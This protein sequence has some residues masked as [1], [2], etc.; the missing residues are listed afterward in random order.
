MQKPEQIL[1]VDAA[2]RRYSSY[3]PASCVD[4][5]YE[6]DGGSSFASLDGVE[7][8]L[9]ESTDCKGW[10]GE[11]YVVLDY[12]IRSVGAFARLRGDARAAGRGEIREQSR[13][14]PLRRVSR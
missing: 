9:V 1:T 5:M 7:W 12:G 14:V 2:R 3:M 11:H 8:V 6:Y 4:G 10:Y 13:V